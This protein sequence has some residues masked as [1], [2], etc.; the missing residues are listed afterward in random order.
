MVMIINKKT[1]RKAL[2]KFLRARGKNKTFNAKKHYGAIRF[3][4]DAVT[5]QKRLRN[6]WK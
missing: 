4:E 1:S 3:E 2:E 6:E 5:I